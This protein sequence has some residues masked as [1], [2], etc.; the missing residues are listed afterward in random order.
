MTAL[1]SRGAGRPRNAAL[2][3]AILTAA[4]SQLRQV[5]YGRMSLETVAIGAGTTVPTV[6]RRHSTKLDLVTAVI[7]SMRIAPMP[8]AGA[9]PRAVTLEILRNFQRNLGRPG[10]LALLGSLLAE[11]GRHPELLARFKVRLVEPRR[12]LLRASLAAGV[13]AGELA[14]D[15]DIDALASMLIGSFYARYL[16]TAGL[17]ANWAG[18]ALQT[19]WVHK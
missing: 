6:R 4:E 16:T 7:D 14:A 2:D 15:T 11:E 10:T 17:P 9:S 18:R 19:V 13:Q 12:A 1:P 3:A 5:G 8:G